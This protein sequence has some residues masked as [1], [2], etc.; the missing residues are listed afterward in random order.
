MFCEWEWLIK[1]DFKVLVGACKWQCLLIIL[2]TWF[3]FLYV[4]NQFIVVSVCSKCVLRDALKIRQ[5]SNLGP[6][7]CIIFI[8]RLQ[9]FQFSCLLKD[10]DKSAPYQ[11][12]CLFMDSL[13]L[14][15]SNTNHNIRGGRLTPGLHRV[16]TS[17]K[18]FAKSSAINQWSFMSFSNFFQIL[19]SLYNSDVFLGTNSELMEFFRF[20]GE[21]RMCNIARAIF[22][23]VI[24]EFSNKTTDDVFHKFLCY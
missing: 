22:A 24:L 8:S 10:R 21:R 19:L 17:G 12:Q 14:W 1:F 18:S 7:L 2:D 15:R 23:V 6:L 11:Y 5:R 20:E 4:R 16:N 9:R 3:V 13:V